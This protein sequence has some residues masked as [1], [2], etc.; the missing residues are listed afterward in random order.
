MDNYYR[1]VTLVRESKNTRAMMEELLKHFEASQWDLIVKVTIWVPDVDA[2]SNNKGAKP[3][4]TTWN[5]L[6][7]KYM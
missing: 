7:L 6:V 1:K 4:N 5:I 2:R 3:V